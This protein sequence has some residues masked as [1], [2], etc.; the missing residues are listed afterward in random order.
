MK[1]I[2]RFLVLCLACAMLLGVMAIPAAAVFSVNDAERYVDQLYTGLL[3]RTADEG[4]R[5]NY[6]NQLYNQNV[7]AG[8]VAQAILGSSE[9]RARQLNNE[10]YV[11]TLYKGLLGREADE[12]GLASYLSFMDC[13]QSRAWV[14]LQILASAEFK[15]RCENYFNMYVGSYPT[16]SSSANPNP[17]SVNTTEASAFVEGLYTY[18]LDRPADASGLQYWVNTLALRKMSAAGVA[19]AMASSN[20]FNA[21]SYTNGEFITRCYQALLGRAPDMGGYTN[22]INALNGG[23]SRS[24]VF[25]AICSSAEFQ[26]RAVF[27]PGG[28]NVTPGIV[29]TSQSSAVNGGAVNPTMAAEYVDRLYLNLLGRYGSTG[30]IQHW[31]N[32]LVNR[33]LSAAGVAAY[34]AASNEFRAISWNREDFV[35]RLYGGLLGRGSDVVGKGTYVAALQAGYSRSWV[36]C[37]IVSSAEFQN[38]SL[39]CDMNVVPGTLNY[40]SYDMG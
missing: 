6:V 29:T 1:K 8:S 31:V 7:S 10:E 27:A 36:F 14:Y 13:G 34:I 40:A 37:K 25:S 5:T 2:K 24:W 18:L 28:A 38:Q 39:F 33:E 26:N 9:F 17:T 32:K 19:C 22:Y 30:E 3:N 16:G 21:K 12:A 35:E 23:K 4:G 11:R 15:N 20:E